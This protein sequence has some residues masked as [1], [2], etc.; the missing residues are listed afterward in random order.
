M[1]TKVLCILFALTGLLHIS[2]EQ[3]ARPTGP[4]QIG[5]EAFLKEAYENGESSPF[6][7]TTTSIENVTEASRTICF[8]VVPK[9]ELENLKDEIEKLRD[10]IV[11]TL[12]IPR[13]CDCDNLLR[14]PAGLPGFPVS[15]FVLNVKIC[16]KIKL[17]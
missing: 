17:K 2:F 11:T 7:T 13:T 10:E 8:S 9:T 6:C 16:F 5:I 14:G 3:T 12:E 4:S 15:F 1:L